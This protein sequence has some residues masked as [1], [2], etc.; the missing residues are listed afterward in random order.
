MKL[1]GWLW[2][3]LVAYVVALAVAVGTAHALIPVDPAPVCEQTGRGLV[4][5]HPFIPPCGTRRCSHHA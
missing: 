5:C 3:W 4:Y 1:R 2:L